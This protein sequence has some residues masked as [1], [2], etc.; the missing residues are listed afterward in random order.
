[1]VRFVFHSTIDRFI[2]RHSTSEVTISANGTQSD[3]DYPTIVADLNALEG[4]TQKDI[5]SKG[6]AANTP[7]QFGCGS[8]CQNQGVC[9][10]VA[11]AVSCRCPNGYSGLQCQVARKRCVLPSPP[12]DDLIGVF[13]LESKTFS[14]QPKKVVI[15]IR[16]IMVAFA[17]KSILIRSIALVYLV[18][19]DPCVVTSVTRPVP[20][21]TA[22]EHHPR[23]LSFRCHYDYRSSNDF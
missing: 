13:L 11:Q 21:P 22:N 6:G 3:D 8:Y 16:V 1:M 23:C 20:R 15:L 12:S 14:S 18:L 19:L 2:P 4:P 5:S 7:K 9:V 17:L 10:I